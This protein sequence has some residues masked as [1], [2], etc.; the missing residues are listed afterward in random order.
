MQGRR[1]Q[2][3][4]ITL[5]IIAVLVSAWPAAATPPSSC[6][7]RCGDLDIPYP[8]GIGRGCYLYTGE[9]DTTFGLTCKL[10]ADGTY[11][12][13]C[14]DVQ[15]IGI[16]L[17]RGQ[18]RIRS[19]IRSW[20][21]NRTSMSM[22]KNNVWWSDFTDSQFRL[23]DEDNRFTVIGCNSLAYVK[24]ANTGSKYMT[25]CMATCP[26]AGRLENGSCS[27][28]G[29]CQA[30][31]PRGINTYEVQFDDR[32]TTS[33]TRGFG[34]CS[35]A[36][37]V[38]AAA[39]DFRTTYVT[40]DDFMESTGGKAPLVLDWVVGKGT[41]REAERN[42][43]AYMCVSGNSECV[44]SRNGPGYL[45]NC[46]RG[47]DG[48]PYVPDGCQDVNECD[49]TRFKYPCSV[50]GT[51][52][53]TAGGYLCSC[54]DKTTGNAYNGTC[55]AKKSQLGVRMALG[56]S[57][58]VVV[59]V[60]A[61][62]CAYMIHQKRS[63]AAVKQRYFRQHGGLLLF[64][65]MKSKQGLS[66]TLFTKEE[67]EEATGKFD[68]RNVL[69]KGGNGTVYKG[70]LKDKR[71]VAIKKCKLINERQE[72]EF[73]KEMLILSQVNHRNVVRL[74]GC[75]LEVEVPMLV[76]EFIPNGTLYQ[77]IHGRPHGSRISFTTRLKIAHETAETLAYL[78]SWASPPIIHGDV[79]S[80]NILI[81]EDYTAKVADFGASALAPTDEAQFVTFV[82]GTYG[83]LDPE[84]MQTS[85]L[86][87]KSDVYSFGVVLLE[88]LTCRKAMNLQALE[89]EKN[90]S[91]HFLLAESENRLDEILDEQIKG[92]QSVELIEQ[93]AE[94][95]KE[96]LEMASDK[97]PSMREVAEELDRVRKMLQHPWGQQT[98]DEERKALL[99]GS[100]STCPKVELSNGY[101]SLSDSAYLGV[102][103]PR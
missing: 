6:Q 99:I 70:V 28:M 62:S 97:R 101:V 77:L 34:R 89:E 39:F 96:C 27:G 81:G 38:E 18:A 2:M 79:K 93:V 33:R 59:L 43:T 21:Y 67:L 58:G 15:V 75:C 54:P 20:C 53:N 92:E 102:Q 46:S 52:V 100:P 74:Y 90:L 98:C 69:G 40:A 60:V 64:E 5:M 86:T 56:I 24:S 22:D 50:P 71:L 14:Y 44:D 23:S 7:R 66:F 83:Y 32:F 95:A 85:K 76:Y 25:G 13:F 80:P 88:L 84:Y 1:S 12:A 29:C 3:L 11:K 55:D 19:D 17:R 30:A 35:Y 48:N 47:Y 41:C 57:I 91:S 49:D 63:L 78:H 26:A 87:S 72:K 31:I 37:L 103:S 68:E 8:F 51:C 94:L 82:Q 9:G 36:V 45:C 10:T 61:T 73:G 16:S 4:L 65:E 42:A